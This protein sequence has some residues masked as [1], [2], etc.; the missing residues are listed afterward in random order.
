LSQK[1]FSIDGNNFRK[2]KDMSYKNYEKHS[3]TYQLIEYINKI[4]A[5]AQSRMNENPNIWIG[6]LT[7]DPDHWADYGVYTPE[8]FERYLD[9]EAKHCQEKEARTFY[10]EDI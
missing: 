6:K 8:D 7:N 2:G 3:V 9:N 5:D 4:N 10:G 1:L